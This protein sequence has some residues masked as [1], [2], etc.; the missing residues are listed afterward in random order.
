MP[1]PTASTRDPFDLPL[2]RHIWETKYRYPESDRGINDTWSRVAAAVS[3]PE[4]TGRD[5]WR[6]EF[7]T[8][9]RDFRFLPGG[10]ILAGAGTGRSVTLFNCFVMGHIEDSLDGIFDA[11]KEGALTMQQGG[12]IGNDFSTLRPV[13]GPS[14]P[15]LSPSCASGTACAQRCCPPATGA[16]R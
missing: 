4:E 6:T 5:H 10:R 15:G 8:L 13:M 11:L 12:G 1:Q 14:R 2:S 7:R 9:L 3:A 16:A